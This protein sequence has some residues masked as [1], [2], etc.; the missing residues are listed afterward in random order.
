LKISFQ[1]NFKTNFFEGFN[2]AH[3]AWVCGHNFVNKNYGN[4]CFKRRIAFNN[5]IREVGYSHTC[6]QDGKCVLVRI[7]GETSKKS[8]IKFEIIQKLKIVF[9][10]N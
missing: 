6:D 7:Y 2:E 5:C 3:T 1:F 9:V 10:F 4:L 8:E